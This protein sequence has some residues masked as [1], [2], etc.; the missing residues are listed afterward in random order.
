MYLRLRKL[1][2]T[3]LRAHEPDNIFLRSMAVAALTVE[4]TFKLRTLYSVARANQSFLLLK[5][6]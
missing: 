2:H 4:K 3:R 1:E 5:R 6:K